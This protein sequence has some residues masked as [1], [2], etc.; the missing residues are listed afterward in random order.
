MPPTRIPSPAR[1]LKVRT[2]RR[3]RKRKTRSVASPTHS[4]NS[5]KLTSMMPDRISILTDN[6]DV[7]IDANNSWWK[8]LSDNTIDV[9]M[10]ECNHLA[11]TNN[12]LDQLDVEILSQ[13]QN[14]NE[15]MNIPDSSDSEYIDSIVVPNR[16]L[17]GH[18]GNAEGKNFQNFIKNREILNKTQI[19]ETV[20]CIASAVECNVDARVKTLFGH[21]LNTT[22]S[23]F[24][25]K[26]M[27]ELSNKTLTDKTSESVLTEHRSK[28]RNI[29]GFNA[30]KQA[31]DTERTK[32]KN[33]Y[34]EFVDSGSEEELPEKRSKIFGFKGTQKPSNDFAYTN[35][36]L[37][38]PISTATD[39]EMEEW[40]LLPSSTMI[41]HQLEVGSPKSKR[42][43]NVSL[44]NTQENCNDS[45]EKVQVSQETDNR[46][47]IT[48]IQDGGS[49]EERNNISA[50]PTCEQDDQLSALE[51]TLKSIHSVSKN[52][53]RNNLQQT[54]N[55]STNNQN[56]SLEATTNVTLDNDKTL[57]PQDQRTSKNVSKSNTDKNMSSKEK[58]RIKN[59]TSNDL[60]QRSSNKSMKNKTFEVSCSDTSIQNESIEAIRHCNTNEHKSLDFQ[61]H[62]HTSIVRASM[63][64]NNSKIR[65]SQ[66]TKQMKER[67]YASLQNC[68][69][70]SSANMSG[71]DSHRITRKSLRKTFGKDFTL[72]KSLRTLVMEKSARRQTNFDEL[73][74]LPI[75]NST[76]YPHLENS[77]VENAENR[78]NMDVDI[79]QNVENLSNEINENMDKSQ[80]KDNSI[81]G[82]KLCFGTIPCSD[83][84]NDR[85]DDQKY[86][87]E[88]QI[89][90]GVEND[91][92][93]EKLKQTVAQ[94]DNAADLD[95]E[96]QSQ[97]EEIHQ[98]VSEQE[99]DSGQE[100]E[101]EK[102]EESQQVE[103]EQEEETVQNKDSQQEES[104]QIESEQEEE[105]DLKENSQ[106]LESEQQESQR[107]ESEQED[108][109]QDESEQEESQQEESQVESEQEESQVESEQDE[110]RQV[111]SEQEESQQS[112]SEQD[113]DSQQ[114]Q[115]SQ[116]ME[117]AQ[118]ERGEEE[119]S[120]QREKEAGVGDSD[121]NSVPNGDVF[122]D[123]ENEYFRNWNLAH[124]PAHH[125]DEEHRSEKSILT[126]RTKR[127]K[128]EMYVEK[129][130]AEN[131]AILRKLK[132][133][134]HQSLEAN[135]MK[136]DYDFKVPHRPEIRQTKI[137]KTRPK[138][139]RQQ[140]KNFLVPLDNLPK[141]VLKDF[142]YKPPK[143]YQPP[144]ASWATKR[145]Y[146]FLETK[147]EPKYSYNARIRAERLVEMFY[148]LTR[149]IRR[150]EVA[151]KATVDTLKHEMARMGVVN[152]H[153]DFYEFFK[154]FMPRMVRIKVVPDIVNNIDLPRNGLFSSIINDV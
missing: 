111:E 122:S 136:C 48:N 77:L 124:E 145:L 80:A 21:R 70:N 119:S 126:P 117:S 12:I 30:P 69:E 89:E 1:S 84:N 86:K 57:K 64:L 78:Q 149:E 26:L 120:R 52:V 143:R 5:I 58:S 138:I 142:A 17:F 72:R 7:D 47:T 102:E 90:G 16:K 29:F 144:K 13:G 24:R 82:N 54:S 110:S 98:V 141:E 148:E 55:D 87:S 32:H 112:E 19:N 114:E 56:K 133:E 38:S 154:D 49:L 97:Q 100:D 146:N 115:D 46:K 27:N 59:Q 34:F 81:H 65:A 130:K 44:N 131:S 134:V 147:L 127:T 99:E 76:E 107:V 128:L 14:N 71:W 3:Y 108:L 2:P 60:Q 63:T 43:I 88:N 135:K 109:Q 79:E 37:N 85:K 68:T 153:F 40:I 73:T 121:D 10:I 83:G 95:Q 45:V 75:A 93:T 96:E 103:S 125:N 53:T 94:L 106:H 74:K 101:S 42:Q 92:E 66:D 137:V 25:A 15:S 50:A 51:H 61:D 152:T 18:N 132:E 62:H 116:Q 105:S 151:P 4:D 35:C 11:G 31:K 8:R 33:K 118:G 41:G 22:K 39:S 113:Q 28:T 140:P 23:A 36:D 20:P 9:D 150:L 104:Q 129:I 91:K 6:T 139:K 67:D 123:N